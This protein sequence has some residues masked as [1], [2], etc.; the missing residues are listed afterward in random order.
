VYCKDVNKLLPIF[1]TFFSDLEKSV[2][3]ISMEIVGLFWVGKMGIVQAML[4]WGASVSFSPYFPHF[5]ILVKFGV[6]CLSI[7]LFSFSTFYWNLCEGGREVVH[8][9]GLEFSYVYTWCV[10]K[11]WWM[12]PENKQHRKKSTHCTPLPRHQIR[13][14]R[15]VDFF[16][17]PCLKSIMKGAR[18][19]DV[20]AIQ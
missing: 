9:S 4:Y 3:E 19:A 16:L 12:V 8:S 18:F 2:I 11:I 7:K 17:F 14:L 13:W 15:W 20:T 6:C 10:Y 1:C 5:L